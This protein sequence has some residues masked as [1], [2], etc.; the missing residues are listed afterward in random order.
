MGR[1]FFS[2]VK[3]DSQQVREIAHAFEANGV[4]TWVDKEQLIPGQ[5]F[6]EEIRSA[7]QQGSYYIDVY[8]KSR[9]ERERTYA[10][11]ELIIA[12]EEIQMRGN[13]AGWYIAITLDDCNVPDHDIGGSTRLSDFQRASLHVDWD[14][15][16]GRLLK[17][18][19]V[20]EPVLPE[21]GSLGG[22][23][24]ASVKLQGGRMIVAETKPEIPEIVG[25]EVAV[26]NGWCKKTAEGHILA[27]IESLSPNPKIQKMN[28]A[29]E[30][31]KFHM[32]SPDAELSFDEAHPNEFSYARN[33]TFRK[34][35]PVYNML[36]DSEFIMPADAPV[37]TRVLAKG[38][39]AGGLFQGTFHN[40]AT[41]DILESR[42]EMETLGAF[43]I[44]WR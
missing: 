2:H 1:A 36:M 8:S 13:K 39:M 25:L 26:T 27:Y 18:V 29:L 7:I 43:E 37:K 11:K 14:Q 3:E 35:Q 41:L 44:E 5:N 21:Q 16:L 33:Y 4:A 9:E 38:F 15:Q 32:L 12:I 30:L 34:G 42:I 24:P 31:S 40:T 23:L 6:H 19:G 22:G 10:N 20:T 17:A 28:E